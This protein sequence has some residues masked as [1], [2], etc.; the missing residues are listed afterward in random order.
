MKMLPK[1][2]S[3]HFSWKHLLAIFVVLLFFQIL[4]SQLEHNTLRDLLSDTMDWY[5][6]NSA[7]QIANLTTASIEVLLERDPLGN[8]PDTEIRVKS[9]VH[10]LN[11]IL[12]QPL[13]KRNVEEMCI[14]LPYKNTFV[15]LDHGRDLYTYFYERSFYT[16]TV[17]PVYAKA[18]E[19]YTRIHTA[20]MKS[21]L[22]TSIQEGQSTFHVY[23]PLV[24]YGEYVGAVYLRIHPDV[25]SISQQI[26]ASFN[27]TVFVFSVLVLMGLLGLFYIS[28]YT[29][30]ERDE[31]WE[32]L[33][34][35]REAHAR[36]QIAQKKERLFTKRIYHTHHKA[37]KVMGF[38]NE[39]VDQITHENIDT[40]KYRIAKYANFIARVIYDMKW[41]NPPL[42][43]IRSPLF[44]T[45][46]NEVLR[47]IVENIFLRVSH[48]VQSIRFEFDL[49]PKLP[50]VSVNEF[51]VW[52]IVEPLIQNAIDHS[53]VPETV[54][55]L[56][57]Q[58]LPEQQCSELR[59]RD[60]GKGIRPDLLER[61]EAGIRYLFLENISTKEDESKHR[62]YGCYLAYEIAK[63]CGWELDADNDPMGGSV[64]ILRIA[65]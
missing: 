25:S 44:R 14:I 16:P 26:L 36:E 31:A 12:K 20:M 59:I 46:L 33:A 43:T 39:D 23:V 29:I 58:H 22:I 48:P 62:G 55:T 37:E 38:I 50:A 4:I 65:H 13:M 30:I 28:T 21:E 3:L 9:L 1:I 54:I 6:Q 47:F 57:T 7:E 18:V 24:P 2:K 49:D 32:L 42:N 11:S 56:Q 41:Y 45:D 5:K 10:A 52:E 64:F 40:M 27:K 8:V 17:T 15:A 60:N 51:V 34:L 63:R 19:Q 53:G 35:E 61:N